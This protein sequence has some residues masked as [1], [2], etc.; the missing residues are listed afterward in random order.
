MG[1]AL[2]L[3]VGVGGDVA[4]SLKFAI[5]QHNPDFIL[6][7]CTPQSRRYAEEVI[8]SRGLP[9]SRY[10]VDEFS[11]SDDV[12]RLVLHYEEVVR[13]VLFQEHG[14][15]PDQVFV[16]YTRGTKAMSAAVD[17]V[18]ISLELAG[19]S[20]IGGERDEEGRVKSGTERLLSFRPL[21]LLFQRHWRTLV[22]LFNRGHF[23]SVLDRVEALRD[24][25][26]KDAHRKRLR[27]LARLAEA[28]EAWDTLRYGDAGQGFQDVIGNFGDIIRELSLA[29]DLQ[30]ASRVVHVIW[31]NRCSDPTCNCGLPLKPETALDLLAHADRRAAEHRYDVAVALLYRLMEFM[32]QRRLHDRGLRTDDVSLERLAGDVRSKWEGRVGVD[33]RLRVGMVQGYEL[34]DDLGDTLGRRF[35]D[36]Y[37]DPTSRLKPYLESRNMSPL[38]HGFQPVG[39]EVFEKLRAVITETFLPELVPDWA[40]RLEDYRLPR[41]P[42]EAWS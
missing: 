34:L 9:E 8:Q 36:L 19:I 13:R 40:R 15:R 2:V 11:E 33:G 38:A 22:H 24:H 23:A 1:K 32:A 18:A 28:C 12:Q 39:P 16:D 20:Y 29:D 17:Y 7:L 6:F 25:L 21:E 41:L 42:E 35:L 3:T 14:L 5:D 10:A 30:R 37:R 31:K 27:F 26:I 4:R